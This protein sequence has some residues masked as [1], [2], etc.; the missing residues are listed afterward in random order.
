MAGRWASPPLAFSMSPAG[1]ES[2]QRQK[3]IAEQRRHENGDGG[4]EFLS[5]KRAE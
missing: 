3:A 4:N 1:P 5:L 2:P